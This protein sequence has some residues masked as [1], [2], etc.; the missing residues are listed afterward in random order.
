MMTIDTMLLTVLAADSANC[1]R[2]CSLQ[3]RWLFKCWCGFSN[4]ASNAVRRS[5]VPAYGM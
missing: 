4:W 5:A 1:C 2:L 3:Q